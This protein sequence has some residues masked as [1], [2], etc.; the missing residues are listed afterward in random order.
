MQ[1]DKNQEKHH[2]EHLIFVKK[3]ITD[4][5]GKGAIMK[6]NKEENELD[7]KCCLVIE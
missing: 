5:Y 3:S 6:T 1:K 4:K 2:R 7:E